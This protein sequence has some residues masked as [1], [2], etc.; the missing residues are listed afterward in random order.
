MA[1]VEGNIEI[2]LFEPDGNVEV[3]IKNFRRKSGK[4]DGAYVIF[5]GDNDE[6]HILPTFHSIRPV[7]RLMSE[8]SYY[9]PGALINRY[10]T[11]YFKSEV[12]DIEIGVIEG[13]R[14]YRLITGKQ[15]RL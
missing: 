1:P 4:N 9:Y 2:D 5:R 8:G 3:E 10:G 7:Y 15:L 14:Q 12:F 6:T 13:D 11:A